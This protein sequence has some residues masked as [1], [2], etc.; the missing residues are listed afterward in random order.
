[1][2]NKEKDFSHY[3][4]FRKVSRWIYAC[5]GMSVFLIILF[6]SQK[7]FMRYD[8][9]GKR[10]SVLS[11]ELVSALK[12]LRH[13]T[14]IY[15]LLPSHDD[16]FTQ[17]FGHHIRHL[18]RECVAVCPHKLQ[19][20]YTNTLPLSVTLEA[21]I[22]D[23]R[24]LPEK[25]SLLL[26]S[27][28]DYRRIDGKKLYRF[29]PKGGLEFYGESELLAQL[30]GLQNSFKKKIYFLVGHGEMF[31]RSTHAMNG[32]SWAASFLERNNYLIEEL[33]LRQRNEIPKDASVIVIAGALSPL[34]KTEIELL[35]SYL[36]DRA[37]RL[38]VWLAPFYP[39]GMERLFFHRGI[40][41]DPHLIVD[42]NFENVLPSNEVIIT[43]FADHE[44]TRP[45]FQQK[46]GVLMGHMQSVQ[47][48]RDAPSLDHQMVIPL[49]WSS[50]SAN[51][52]FFNEKASPEVE[53]EISPRQE[54]TSGLFPLG[55]LS[56]RGS[57]PS[58]GIAMDHGKLMVMG[59]V[60]AIT[61]SRI[62]SLGNRQFLLGL[63]QY[64]LEDKE[65]SS[66]PSV[67]VSAYRLQMTRAQ[68]QKCWKVFLIPGLLVLFLALG[69]YIARRDS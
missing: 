20:H 5:I 62:Q 40:W 50:D 61:N 21:P 58:L 56:E 67:E 39:H 24:L 26:V 14:D 38:L 69:V 42:R 64:L 7:Y 44:A 46:L 3:S 65:L 30:R 29:S 15:V 57:N 33:D 66:L 59:N 8:F 18:L 1:M 49:L 47:P 12:N 36:E 52:R 55:I 11:K 25:H 19:V 13:S 9:C 23:L 48:D 60:D 68:M 10:S 16:E 45:V 37:G 4:L 6:V 54:E 41:V 32:L 28:G 43:R 22:P 2:G 63:I 53:K 17:D 35:E 34:M 27:G 51:A 31:L